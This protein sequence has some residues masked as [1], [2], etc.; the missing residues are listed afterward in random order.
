MGADRIRYLVFVCDRWRWRPTRTMRAAG[1]RLINLSKGIIVDGENV[2]TVD[3]KNR[4]IE[5]NEAWDRH[6]RGLEPAAP[7]AEVPDRHPRRRLSAGDAAAGSRAPQRT[8]SSGPRN[9]TAETTGL[10]RGDGSSR[11]SATCDPKTVTPEQ[12]IDPDLPGLRPLVA[13][14]VSE[15]EAHRVIKVWRRLW[16]YAATFELLRRGP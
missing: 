4:A 14:K 5:L 9:S 2:P 15:T 8:A 16:Q 12:L 6:R 1:F 7:E 13:A 3:D 11:S 10:A